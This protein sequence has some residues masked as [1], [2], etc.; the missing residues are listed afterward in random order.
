MKLILYNIDG[1][2]REQLFDLAADPLETKDLSADPSYRERK[3]QLRALL[4]QEMRDKH[5]DLDIDAA[6]WGR[7][8]AR[9]KGRGS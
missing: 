5:D 6:D 4:R 8:A 9:R 3:A 7:A 2:Q 1:Q